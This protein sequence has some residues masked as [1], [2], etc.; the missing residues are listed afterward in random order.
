MRVDTA[1]EIKVM[2]SIDPAAIYNSNGTK[3]GATID[4]KGY[5]SL[6]FVF[7]SGVLTD[8]TWT[9]AIFGSNDSGMSGEVQL[10]TSTGLQAADL[11]FAI[12]DDSLTKRQGVE[13][14][15][16]GYRY[17]RMKATQAAATTGG[18]VA[19]CCIL[20]KPQVAPVAQP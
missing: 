19:G 6:V 20:A 9:T 7:Q 17:Y 2:A 4:A 14:G 18:Y 8:G 16:A 13:V 1:A 12:T 15:K 11:S 5:E 3:T 10:T